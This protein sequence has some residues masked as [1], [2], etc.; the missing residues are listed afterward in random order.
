MSARKALVIASYEYEDQSLR[1]LAAPPRDAENFS[2]VLSYPD[3]GGFE[4]KTLLGDPSYKVN[5]EIEA[6][7]ANRKSDDVVL[8]YFSGHGIK[9]DDGMLYFA[10]IDT[11]R[12]MLRSTAIQALFVNDVMR[13]SRSR[14]QILILDCC[15]SGAFA[16][17]LVAKADRAIGTKE[18]LAGRGRVVL[19]ASDSLQYAFEGDEIV[20]EGACSIFTGALVEGLSSGDAD[21][22]QDGNITF[23][24]LYEYVYQRVTEETPNQIPEKWD[25]GVQG[26]LLV[27]RNPNPIVQLVELPGELQESASDPRSWV[28]EGT[29]REL[30]RLLHSGNLGL[31]KAA[32]EA[33]ERFVEDDSRRVSEAASKSLA[34]FAEKKSEGAQEATVDIEQSAMEKPQTV[35]IA[36]EKEEAKHR[37]R[38]DM[39]ATQDTLEKK[40]RRPLAERFSILARKPPQSEA[41]QQSRQENQSPLYALE[42]EKSRQPLSERLGILTS[43]SQRPRHKITLPLPLTSVLLIMVPILS[44]ILNYWMEVDVYVPYCL[45]YSSSCNID[46]LHLIIAIAMPA[47][48]TVAVFLSRSYSSFLI[49][50]AMFVGVVMTVYWIA[51]PIVMWGI[52]TGGAEEIWMPSLVV[53]AGAIVAAPLYMKFIHPKLGK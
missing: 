47:I 45:R 37:P 21:L 51:A 22:N 11:N 52:I 35:F 8:L 14:R 9:D 2:R 31:A 46:W 44:L 30:E 26:E 3:I 27:A 23:D 25:L 7:F 29:V 24:E 13:H 50:C 17:G 16:R 33:L 28:R 53:F 1:R 15:Y 41:E 36:T 48:L 38:Q 12:K 34:S 19:T 18:R 43:S 5:Q 42:K 4:V 6:M 20:G 10:T 39:Q 40:P 32:F 49:G